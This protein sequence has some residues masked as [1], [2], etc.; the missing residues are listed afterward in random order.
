MGLRSRCAQAEPLLRELAKRLDTTQR[1]GTMFKK[2]SI[3]ILVLV[4]LAML[5]PGCAP[6][7]PAEI[8]IGL[9][10]PMTGDH[11]YVGT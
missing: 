3:S 6:A 1:G 10:V 11:A 9:D 5:L 4:F 2:I 8:K 7:T